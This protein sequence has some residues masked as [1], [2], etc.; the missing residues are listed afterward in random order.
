MLWHSLNETYVPVGA[1]AATSQPLIGSVRLISRDIKSTRMP[2][3]MNL[4]CSEVS[5]ILRGEAYISVDV[6]I[7]PGIFPDAR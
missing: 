7:F 4:G 5:V 3:L 2:H 6:D 1:E